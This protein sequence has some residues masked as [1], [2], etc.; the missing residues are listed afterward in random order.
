MTPQDASTP[1]AE[2]VVPTPSLR[3]APSTA[4]LVGKLSNW[5]LVLV[6]AMLG[7][8]AAWQVGEYT[9][10]YFKPS[11]AAENYQDSRALNAE[12]PAVNSRNSAVAFG[13]LGGLLGLA[14]GL[15]GGLSRRS[16]SGAVMGAIAGLV[17]GTAL[18]ALPSFAVM[19]WQFRHRN[20]DP[21]TTELLTPLLVHLALWSGIGL[22]AG[23]AFGIGSR[24]FKPLGLFE[25]ALA[26]LVGAALGTFVYELAG[27][28]LLPTAHTAD[29]ISASPGSRLL[30]R[31]CV[32]GFV[33]LGAVRSLPRAAGAAT[34]VD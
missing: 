32:A 19:P 16:W 26:G 6:L 28:F 10:D 9:F 21:S 22:A 3:P 8:G 11:K 33:G 31:L 24:G 27:A 25:A 23:L 2:P 4:G 5:A 30:A 18:G 34:K 29:P 7:G 15:A 14:L 17:L 12:M 1:G 13:A 20:D